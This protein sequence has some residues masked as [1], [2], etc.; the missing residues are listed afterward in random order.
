MKYKVLGRFC[1]LSYSYCRIMQSMVN[2]QLTVIKILLH[3]I[4]VAD[5]MI[6]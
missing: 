6:R 4:Y 3:Q 1:I 2:V 5:Y